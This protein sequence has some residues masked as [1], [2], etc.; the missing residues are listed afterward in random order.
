[1]LRERDWRDVS[2]LLQRLPAAW[3]L[4]AE[5]M[6]MFLDR[7]DFFLNSEYASWTADPKTE[8]QRKADAEKR[9]RLGHKTPPAP[10]LY[11]VALRPDDVAAAR[12]AQYERLVAEFKPA[13]KPEL[14]GGGRLEKVKPRD[15]AALLG[16]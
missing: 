10:L 12:K 14:A 5:N 15:L 6:A 4:E 16:F 13:V 1:M 9:R 3:S 8:A 2:E 7:F 11:P